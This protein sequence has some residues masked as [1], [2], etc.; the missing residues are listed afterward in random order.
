MPQDGQTTRFQ[1]GSAF[2]NQAAIATSPAKPVSPAIACGILLV[3]DVIALAAAAAFSYAVHLVDDQYAIWPDYAVVT[4][5]GILL[6]VNVF[7]LAG[8]YEPEILT[9]ARTSLKRAAA[10]WFGVAAGLVILG[11]LTKTSEDYSRL[12][13]MLWLGTGLF[14]LLA[15]RALFWAQAARWTAQG[16]LQKTVILVGAKPLVAH[17]AEHFMRDA[18]S[19][20]VVAGVYS[21]DQRKGNLDDLVA[22]IR[23]GGIDTVIVALPAAA[24][25][26]LDMI[27]SKLLD[28]SVDVRFCPGRA[29]I[30]LCGKGVSEYAGVPTINLLNRPLA[31]WRYAIKNVE[32]R[33]LGTLILLMISPV[34]LAIGLLIKLDSPGP[35]LFRQKRYG[36][37]NQL[38][39]VLKFR[40]MR[41]D[42]TDQKAEQL[43]LRNDPRVTKLGAILRKYSLDELPQF[44]N[45]VRGEM[46]IVGPRPHAVSA[47]AGG[48]L[49]Q[50]AVD[51]YASRHRVKPGITGWAQINGW[52]GTTDTVRQI[53][54]RVEYDLYY[55]DHWSLGLD[56]KIIFLTIFKGFSGEHAY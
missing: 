9:Q 44:I 6:A 37:N 11:F 4:A 38:I 14:A 22:R 53:E 2:A 39:E 30:D 55:I 34:L 47:K 23:R 29:A 3:S 26:R 35:M 40:T 17:L 41:T 56:L 43:T 48:Y 8:L 10:A 33:L 24:R 50:D 51:H 32:D 31:D 54:K 1:R 36:F 46:S 27:R 28:V 15:T 25:R 16:R 21:D 13:A 5:F 42:L 19:G 49:Y 18:K 12:W 20:V 45:V 7:R 52:R